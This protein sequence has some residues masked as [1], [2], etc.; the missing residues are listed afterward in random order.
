M[1]IDRYLPDPLRKSYLRKFVALSSVLLISL[2][3]IGV[4]IQTT[5]ATDLTQQQEETVLTNAETEAGS[6]GEWVDA[7][8]S[9]VRTLSKHNGIT[10]E[11]QTTR[12]ETLQ[13]E[14]SFL[15]EEAA[16]LHILD[17]ESKTITASTDSA[18]ETKGVNATDIVWPGDVAFESVSFESPNDVVQTWMY[19]DNG[20]PSV[21]YVSPVPDSDQLLVMVVRTSDR[22]GG[23]STPING[24]ET[25]VVGRSTGDVLFDTNESAFLTTYSSFGGDG[26]SDAIEASPTGTVETDESIAA[27]APVER[28]GLNWVVVKEAPKSEALAIATQVERNVWLLLGV[29]LLGLVIFVMIIKRGLINE[30]LEITDQATGLAEGNI[31]RKIT[32]EQR[33]DEIG[34]VRGSFR[35]IQSY[36]QTVGSQAD[37]LARQE[38]DDEALSADVPGPLGD[39]LETMR[40]DLETSIEEI[41]AAR[42]EAEELA[43]SLETQAEVFSTQMQRAA[44]GDLTQRLETDVGNESL[45]EIAVA[46]N[47]MLS[48]LEK[49]VVEIQ[50]FAEN[51]ADSADEV[52]TGSEEIK[53][54]AD[55]AARAVEEISDSANRQN[56][57]LDEI[58]QEMT[59]LSATI[60]EVASSA[61]EVA[62]QTETA[63]TAGSEGAELATETIDRIEEIQAKTNGTVDEIEQLTDEVERIDEIVEMID[64]IAEQTNILAL[65]ASIEAAR[66]GEAGE[67]FAV[68]ADEIKSLAEETDDATDEINALI[69]GVQGSTSEAAS[70]VR[71]MRD[72][73]GEGAETIEETITVFDDIIQSIEESNTSV[74]SISEATDDQA[75]SSQEAVTMLE[76]AS[77]QSEEMANES[78]NVS[79]A[80]EE[81]TAAI[82]EIAELSTRLTEQSD[83][84]QSLLTQFETAESV[85]ETDLSTESNDAGTNELQK[86]S[87]NDINTQTEHRLENSDVEYDSSTHVETGR[88][89]TIA[90]GRGND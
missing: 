23:F 27:F 38:F 57:G 10:A 14:L 4:M 3:I 8:R 59:D 20:V 50:L 82:S 5:V 76:N 88:D 44:N 81:Q 87:K 47:Q 18:I 84:L 68:V 12:R 19:K 39:S 83:N 16:N 31:D 69:A 32:N 9:T 41:E 54:A 40:D 46:F 13:E 73:V 15:P 63:A 26:V 37:A 42:A 80:T 85:D 49:T 30:I 53:T 21:A 1:K 78:R 29:A 66:A 67:G 70:D 43:A 65:N 58:V 52:A 36:L 86:T 17:Q 75:A 56:E 62:Q 48:Q 79:A 74:Q 7:Q 89:T 22:A 60:E 90:D 24:T 77:E 55:E 11:D 25:T 6:L 45:S 61:D 72:L 64:Q 71:E 33:I 35:D 34:Q 28:A 2:L 51:V